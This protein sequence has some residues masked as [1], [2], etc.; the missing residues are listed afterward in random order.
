MKLLKQY[1]WTLIGLAVLAVL[2]FFNRDLAVRSASLSLNSVSTMLG[3]LPPILILVNL[4]DAWIPKEV[5]IKHMGE[6]AG[7]NG[8]FWAFV[9]GTLG[10]GPLY[11][12][13][14]VAAMLAKKE[15]RLTYIIFFLGVW[16]TTKLPIFMYE[17]NFFGLTFTSVHVLTGLGSFFLLSLLLEKVLLKNSIGQV[18]ERLAQS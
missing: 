3:I 9:L 13:F 1:K 12:A 8:Y 5:I 18:Y 17:L 7:F 10:A 15:A 2:Y 11:A 4:M 16:T 14:P 6:N